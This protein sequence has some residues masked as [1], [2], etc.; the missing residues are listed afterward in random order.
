MVYV[1]WEKKVTD[2]SIEKTAEFRLE[3]L[4][5]SDVEIAAWNG[6]GLPSDELCVQNG[7]LVTRSSRWP[8]CVDP[9]MQAVTWIKK[10]EEKAGITVKTFNDDYIKFLELSVQYGKPFLFENLDEELDPMVDPVLGQA[11]VIVNGAKMITLGDNQIEWNDN[12]FLM[13]TTKLSNPR[14]S[15]ETMGK[16]SIVNC[17]ITID[18][19]QAQLLNVVVGFE[20][21]DLEQQRQQLVSTMSENKQIL[22]S[23]EDT[24]LRELAASKGR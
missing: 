21:P 15:P 19:L 22:K 6:Q 9:Q 16:V 7:I 23:L 14:Y 1:D 3:T 2:R 11:C 13:M 10:K 5:T 8:L 4:L 17:V 12:F 20:R 24:L 18:G